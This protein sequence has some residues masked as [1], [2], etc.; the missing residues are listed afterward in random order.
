M[1]D[2]A[3]KRAAAVQ[4]GRP[5]RMT[6]PVPDGSIDVGNRA[7]LAYSYYI[8]FISIGTPRCGWSVWP[9][10]R[11]FLVPPAAAVFEIGPADSLFEFRR[12]P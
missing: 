5:F 7:H 9:A 1:T 10:D 6:L 4:V 8:E 3:D 11:V 12:C 2:T